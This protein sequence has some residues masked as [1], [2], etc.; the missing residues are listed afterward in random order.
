[1]ACLI[2]AAC[3]VVPEIAHRPNVHNPFPELSKVAVA[4]FFNLSAEPSVDG[5]QFAIAYFHELQA[6]PGF[7]VVPVG[8]VEQVME[9]ERIV[10][11]RWMRSWS[12]R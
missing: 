1:M 12:E 7:E 10:L 11:S 5:R 2:F 3:H 6:I 9:Q 8:V 4:P